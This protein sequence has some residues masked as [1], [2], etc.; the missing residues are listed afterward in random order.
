[1][2]VDLKQEREL[3]IYP[4]SL[5]ALTLRYC[6]AIVRLW[7]L[8]RVILIE[9]PRCLIPYPITTYTSD[10]LNCRNSRQVA[11][12]STRPKQSRPIYNSPHSQLAPHWF[13]ALTTRPIALTNS[14]H[15][16]KMNLSVLTNRP[17]YKTMG[18]Q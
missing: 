3:L 1:M 2:E 7:S 12:F 13:A 10:Q 5:I 14:P 6:Q 8:N 11:P 9:G 18:K 4:T 15:F 17:T 16:E